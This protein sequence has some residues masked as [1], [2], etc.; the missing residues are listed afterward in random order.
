MFNMTRYAAS[1]IVSV[2]FNYRLGIFGFMN[3]FDEENDE[4]VGGN[5]GL[6][7]QQMAIQ[8]VSDNCH[9]IGCDETRITIFGESA[10]A[11]S[12][13]WVCLHIVF[14]NNVQFSNY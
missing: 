6:L 7:D 8:F 1:D 14:T 9:R 10:G 13:S 12:V 4:V 11:E 3:S 5:Y 2:V